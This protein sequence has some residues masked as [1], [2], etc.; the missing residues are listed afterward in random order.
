MAQ[1]APPQGLSEALI[2]GIHA[3]VTATY[4]VWKAN[5]TQE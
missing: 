3:E 2:A 1:V 5:S 4:G